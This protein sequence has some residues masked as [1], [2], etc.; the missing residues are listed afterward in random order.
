M[1][2]YEFIWT[3]EI[4]AH[5]AEH[6]VS[7]DDFEGVVTKSERTGKSQSSGLPVAW[8]YTDDR[9]YILAV[10]EMIDFTTVLPVTAYEVPRPRRKR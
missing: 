4:I 5:L 3:P 10:Y 2:Y 8:G 6:G 1:P 9:R 7:P